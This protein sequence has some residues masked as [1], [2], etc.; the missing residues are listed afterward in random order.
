MG[1]WIAPLFSGSSGNCT[2]IKTENT[3]ILIDAGLA[4]K[5]ISDA[6]LSVGEDIADI[7]AIIITH[8]HSDHIKGVGVLSR[9][10]DIPVFA[11]AETWCEME[12][13]VGSMALSNER[14]IDKCDFYIG[15][16]CIEPFSV[17]HDAA[18]PFAYSVYGGG[19][20]VTVL[21]DTGRATR[22]ILSHAQESKIVLLESNH[23]IEMLKNGSYPKV[24]KDRI[25]STR[26]HLSNAD[27]AA[28]AAEL[29]KCG[30]RGIMLGHL[31]RE[32]NT[33]SVAFGTVCEELKKTGLIAGRDLAL[34]IA[35]KDCATG[36]Y[37][38][39]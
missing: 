18:N 10:Y 35:Q 32:N 31:S 37:E 23:D 15:E 4:G 11:N 25:L 38:V 26:G 2:L 39:K 21:T 36:I 1:L 7:D 29:Y 19:A 9:R 24:L 20:K 3:R 34:K 8:E 30:T 28:A 12:A 16:L 13:K 22:E 5:R 6:L 27:A 33:E 14:I 17:S